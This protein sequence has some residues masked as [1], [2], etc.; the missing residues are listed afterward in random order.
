LINLINP[1]P[2]LNLII[3][4]FLNLYFLS[5]VLQIDQDRAC[6]YLRSPISGFLK[7]A[8][9]LIPTRQMDRA[10][11][12]MNDSL[13]TLLKH[14][15]SSRCYLSKCLGIYMRHHPVANAL[16]IT[17]IV[18][19]IRSHSND[20]SDKHM[21]IYRPHCSTSTERVDEATAKLEEWSCRDTSDSL[22]THRVRAF[23]TKCYLRTYLWFMLHLCFF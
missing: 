23:F 5:I 16:F 18:R 2:V 15:Y 17:Y 3:K 20:V 10:W 13:F 4:H 21:L 12:S 11:L 8:F 6:V 14:W 9:L 19:A 22:M 7:G 1:N